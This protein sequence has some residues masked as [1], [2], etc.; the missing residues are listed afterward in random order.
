MWQV[1]ADDAESIAIGAGILGTGGGGSPYLGKI[2]IQRL[3]NEGA[4]IEV[5]DLDELDDDALVTM[6]AG[7]GAPTVGVEKLFQG[8]EPRWAIEALEAYVGQSIDFVMSAEIGGI[9]STVPLVAA[10]LTGKRVIDGDP[11]GRA[12][13]E[14]QMCTHFIAGVPCSPA[15]MVDEKGN[16]IVFGNV[17]SSFALERFARDLVIP[18]GCRSMFALPVMRGDQVKR[19][20]VRGTLSLVRKIGDAVRE[21]QRQKSS[22]VDAVLQI[23]GGQELFVGKLI[24]V[25]RRTE[26]GF[27]RGEVVV[28]GLDAYRGEFLHIDIQNENL[29]A[30][31]G[32]RTTRGEVAACVPD[33]ICS[34]ETESGEPITTEQLRYGLRVTLLAIPCTDKFRT[35]E[36]LKVVGPAAFGYPDVIYNP[37][38]KIPGVG[39]E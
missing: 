5:I 22:Y 26:G 21:A 23:T 36:A 38:P 17:T 11:M 18:M 27:A 39:I 4:Q 25:A 30:F 13:P 7:L 33:L 24:D 8:E 15:A 20:T 28:E 37:L 32:T 16:R 19:T 9:N 3:L 34:L 1:T 12:F 10:A 31:R 14:M 29:I 2:H 6:V 35:P